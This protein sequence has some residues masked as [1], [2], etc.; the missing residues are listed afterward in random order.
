MRGCH[1]V[2]AHQLWTA[3]LRTSYYMRGKNPCIIYVTVISA[4]IILTGVEFGISCK[5]SHAC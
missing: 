2:D 5:T 4:Q 1:C 3:Y